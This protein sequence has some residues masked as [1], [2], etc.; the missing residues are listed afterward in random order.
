[1]YC[2]VVGTVAQRKALKPTVLCFSCYMFSLTNHFIRNT[3]TSAQSCISV[4][5][6]VSQSCGSS[7]MYKSM[8]TQVKSCL[9]QADKKATI[10]QMSNHYATVSSYVWIHT[11]IQVI[12]IFFF[13]CFS[14]CWLYIIKLKVKK[15]SLST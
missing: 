14:L 3:C 10:S 12:E 5:H 7:T 4:C 13:I 6:P 8:Q 11:W 9:K 1:M 2:T 15:R